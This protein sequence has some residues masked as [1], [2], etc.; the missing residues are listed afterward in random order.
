MKKIIICFDGTCNEPADAEQKSAYFGLGE[1]ED[2]SITN[3]LKLHLL[4]GGDLKGRN[5]FEADGQYCFYHSGVGTYGSLTRKAFNAALAPQNQDVDHIIE[6][7]FKDLNSVYKAGDRIF[8]F[9]FSRGAAIARQFAARLRSNVPEV[10]PGDKP[11][12]FM[13]VFD[14][15][16]VIGE[17]NLDSNEKPVSDVLFEDNF[18][19][20]T[21]QEAL[22]LVALDEKRI[23]FQPTLMNKQDAVTEIWFSGAH[24]DVGGGYRKDGMSDVSLSFMLEQIR[25]RNLGLRILHPKDIEY[26]K[27]LPPSAGFKIDYTDVMI[28]ANPLGTSHQQKRPLLRGKITLNDR[29]LRVN[30]NDRP[31][32]ELPLLHHSVADRIHGDPDYKPQSLVHEKHRMMMPGGREEIFDGLSEHRKFQGNPLL[33][34]NPGQQQTVRV[35]SSLK[36]NPS[37]IQLRKDKR[38]VFSEKKKG[39][40]WYDSTIPAGIEGWDLD[41]VK[42]G[43]KEFFIRMSEDERRVPDAK[44]FE[45]VATLGKSDKNA[46]RILNHLDPSTPYLPPENGEFS[47]FANDLE[48]R[49]GNNLGYVDIIVHCI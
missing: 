17:A 25:D 20:D 28:N 13:G 16:A 19:A 44:W 30:E 39:Q 3:V 37:G 22:H 46:F 48:S 2:S 5:A 1:L 8:L 41:T 23:G 45:L 35:F 24:A 49:Y 18:I 31:S 47:P 33:D 43:F 26:E 9:G 34:L 27:L 32:A 29:E 12:R 6:M 11:V 21:V 14:T 42:L 38:Y 15:V 4:L 7:G 10:K 36:Y 40:Q